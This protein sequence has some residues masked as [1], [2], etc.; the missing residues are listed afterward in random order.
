MIIN[1]NHL[2]YKILFLSFFL[3]KM[4]KPKKPCLSAYFNHP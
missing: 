1:Y 4:K 3:Y 2:I